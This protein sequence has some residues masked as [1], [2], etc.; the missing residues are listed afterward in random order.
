M[1]EA[2]DALVG[3][4]E[5]QVADGGVG[6]GI[7][8]PVEFL[9]P[10]AH[11]FQETI[12]SHDRLGLGRRFERSQV[13]VDRELDV[14]VQ[15]LI[16]GQQEREVGSGAALDRSLLA[17]VDALAHAG[18]AQNILGHTLT[19]LATGLGAGKRLAEVLRGLGEHLLLLGGC[20]E[21]RDELAVLFG[22][23]PLQLRDK[24]AQLA[25][26]VA[27]RLDL[28]TEALRHPTDPL[29][30]GLGH[31]TDAFGDEFVDRVDLL[32]EGLTTPRGGRRSPD[33]DARVRPCPSATAVEAFAG[34]AHDPLD[35]T[36]ERARLDPAR[37]R[38][39][40]TRHR[41]RRSDSDEGDQERDHEHGFHA[42]ST[43][44]V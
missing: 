29:A 1:N 39:T 34:D 2:V 8:A 24:V 44:D 30:D 36:V 41:C 42:L 37:W 33:V 6:R 17:V 22:A 11:I 19:P 26:L 20:F 14:H 10:V 18:G 15:V 9:H 13:V 40:R 43:K 38:V 35:D 32:G 3:D 28:V 23:L 5:Q 21:R 25:E 7:A 31:A 4:E 27:H 16:V 12:T